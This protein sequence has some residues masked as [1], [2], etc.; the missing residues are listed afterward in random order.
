MA[1]K[2]S[3]IILNWNGFKDTLECLES[4]G[5]LEY[6]NFDIIVVDNG[7][8]DQSVEILGDYLRKIAQGHT[9][10][11]KTAG[12]RFLSL[13]HE[14]LQSVSVEELPPTDRFLF[15]IKNEKN[16]GF[17]EGNNIAIRFALKLKPDFILLLNNDTVVDRRLLRELV[18][19]AESSPDIGMVGPKIFYYDYFGR[20]DILNSAG[21][22]FDR[23]RGIGRVLGYREE[24][25]A[26]YDSVRE[27]DIVEGSCVL[28]PRRVLSEVGLLDPDYFL[29]WEDTD[30]CFRVR[31][32][33][34]RLMFTPRAMIW[35]KV[36]AASKGV[37][38]ETSVY[39]NTRNSFLF[40]SKHSWG[41]DLLFFLLYFAYF[42][43]WTKFLS[44]AI[45][46]KNKKAAI[47]YVKGVRDGLKYLK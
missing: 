2:V 13:A 20:K 14:E 22:Y 23:R 32:K 8:R 9:T 35:H 1:P 28:I 4:L 41:N 37:L 6:A 3:I 17:A 7:S 30:L 24:D 19:V 46:Y 45:K 21:E 43:S 26:Q 12:Y 44:Y 47:T 29:Y 18:D 31:A 42:R 38:S 27:V 10:F 15:L 40:M 25:K 34:Y 11:E 39:Y 5:S 33:G 16:Y 36:S